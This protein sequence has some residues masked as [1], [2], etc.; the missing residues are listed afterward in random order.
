MANETDK[1]AWV[2]RVL[3]L[4]LGGARRIAPEGPPVRLLPVWVAAKDGVDDAIGALQA[5]LRQQGRPGLR[6]IA[7]AGLSAVTDGASVGMMVALREFDAAPGSAKA[8][9]KLADAAGVFRKFLAGDKVV[10]LLADN[11]F[12]VALPLRETFGKALDTIERRIAA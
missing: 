9:A 12:G 3:G 11:P 10:A 4:D 5:A 1:T 8:K 7:D 2:L 6:M